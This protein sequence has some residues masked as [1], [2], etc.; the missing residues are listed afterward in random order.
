MLSL[1]WFERVNFYG[2]AIDSCDYLR[3]AVQVEKI[4]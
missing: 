1:M 2:Y 4:S 3:D